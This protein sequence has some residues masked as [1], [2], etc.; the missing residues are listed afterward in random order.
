LRV[1]RSS[2]SKCGYLS[3]GRGAAFRTR[4]AGHKCHSSGFAKRAVRF[5]GYSIDPAFVATQI[6]QS[7]CNLGLATIDL[8]LLHNPE[9]EAIR[10]SR[11]QL[12]RRLSA[13]FEALEYACDDG[14]IGG[15]GVSTWDAFR[16]K[17]IAQTYFGLRRL[18]A[19]ARGVA[20]DGSHFIAVE[21]PYNV[22]SPEI[23]TRKWQRGRHGPASLL[24]VAAEERI[25]VL[26]SSTLGGG[27]LARR[28]VLKGGPARLRNSAQRAIAF[29]CAAPGITCALV[30]TRSV[31]H[32][33]D[34]LR[35]ATP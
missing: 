26:T 33:D 35:S 8:Y 18:C 25:L 20:G 1:T 23:A 11:R 13:A 17:P 2:S 27:L 10:L 24:E 12:E 34:A 31:A 14:K 16:C 15:Y 9:V 30:G 29:A 5:G 22:L 6:D 32:L 4:R 21:A 28:G 19:I 7:R 3:T